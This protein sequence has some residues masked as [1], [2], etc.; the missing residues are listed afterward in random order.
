M[1]N[2]FIAF[3]DWAQLYWLALVVFMTLLWM[4]FLLMIG[5]SWLYGYWSNGLHGTKFD[6]NS[7]WQGISVVAAAFAAILALAKA[8][9]TKWKTDSEFN[10]D[11]GIAPTVIQNVIQKGDVK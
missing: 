3:C 5:A 11:Q 4:A 1:K 7:C 10:T 9:W 6:I 2:K 8:G